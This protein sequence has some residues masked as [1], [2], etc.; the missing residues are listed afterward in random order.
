M[1]IY[2]SNSYKLAR[3]H[4]YNAQYSIGDR[5][6]LGEDVIAQ[7]GY[8]SYLYVRGILHNRFEKGETSMMISRNWYDYVQYLTSI[9]VQIPE[10]LTNAYNSYHYARYVLRSVY[11]EGEVYISQHDWCSYMYATTILGDRFLL[12]E[13]II[14]G[15]PYRDQYLEF[16]SNL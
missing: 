2:Q 3:Y 1:G 5:Y 8:F 4:Y 12:G 13:P 11:T 10:V 9:D 14:L 7:D 6:L 15:S 16:T